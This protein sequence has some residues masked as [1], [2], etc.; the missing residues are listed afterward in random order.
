MW[1]QKK[2]K[3][4]PFRHCNTATKER[5][6]ERERERESECLSSPGFLSS[7]LQIKHRWTDAWSANICKAKKTT[8]LLFI[9]WQTAALRWGQTFKWLKLNK[10]PIS[11]TFV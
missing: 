2:Y 11:Y 6:R 3:I 9:P 4:A 7:A 10:W 5:E 1:K 8:K